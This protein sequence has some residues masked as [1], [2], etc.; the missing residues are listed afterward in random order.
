MNDYNIYHNHHYHI[1]YHHNKMDTI[2][3]L[4]ISVTLGDVDGD[5]EGLFDGET[6]GD[7]DGDADGDSL[8]ELDGD[9]EGDEEACEGGA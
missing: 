4:M 8:G 3:F 1:P 9:P 2:Y 7:E 5:D 6:L